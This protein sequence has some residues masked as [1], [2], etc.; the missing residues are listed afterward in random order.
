MLKFVSPVNQSR[1]LQK[2]YETL[3]CQESGVEYHC[4]DGIWR[5]IAPDRWP[6]YAQFVQEYEAVRLAE[7]R[8][9]ADR[10]FYR[11]LPLA[12]SNH[13]AAAMWQQRAASYQLFVDKIVKKSESKST[14]KI[15]DMG[16]GNG[17]LANRMAQ[18]G[19][20]VGA[21]DLT[22]NDFDGLGVHTNY[23]HD[24][25][26]IQA[27]FDRLPLESD[28]FD[29]L[30]FNA[31]LHYSA[32]YDTTLREAIRVIKSD[33]QIVVLDT[34][35]YENGASGRQMVAEREAD[36]QKQHG[37][38]SNSLNSENFLSHERIEALRNSLHMQIEK[39]NVVPDF[40]RAVRRL[41]TKIRGQREAA[42][43]PILILRKAAAFS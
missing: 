3:Q 38:K 15:L 11:Q 10:S 33:G 22:T 30:V 28:Q 1:L 7:G 41:K 2:D 5:M 19:H 8:K 36:F 18:R 39:I 24:F 34:P 4:V 42:E 20:T 9:A 31:S 14:L 6:R 26:P 43:F 23:D 29:L 25:V 40:R 35:V 13:P 32:D 17:W 21:V 37:F 27:E 12:A 16:A